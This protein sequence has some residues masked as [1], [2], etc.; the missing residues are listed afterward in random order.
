MRPRSCKINVRSAY[1]ET[2]DLPFSV[3]QGSCA[4]PVLYLVYASTMQRI[5]R[6]EIDLHGYADDHAL[7]I[8]FN[9]SQQNDEQQAIQHLENSA[10]DIKVW[11]DQNRLKMNSSKTEFILFG[12][13]HQLEKS[14]SR[15]L[16]VN[17]EQVDVSDEIKYLG[18]HLDK[19]LTLKHHI[20]LVCRKAMWNIQRIKLVRNVLTS[21]ACETLVLGLVISHLDYANGLYIGLPNCDIQK[22]QRVQ[23]IGAKLVI[24]TSDS[25]HYCL[26][27]LHWLPINLRIKH[28]ILTLLFKSLRGESPKYIRDLVELHSNDRQGLR[29]TNQYMRLKVP[30]TRRKTFASRSFSVMAPTWWNEL[31]NQIKDSVNVDIFKSKLKTFLFN[32]F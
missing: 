29:S 26:K 24:N 5:V 27:K 28:K 23:N 22:L 25:S 19:N 10:K 8:S 18:V 3:P 7:K 32:Q 14:S 6:D 2:K 30:F 31:P 11:M 9:P 12:S 4:G 20:T 1:S 13:S 15:S 17:G 16:N 21:D